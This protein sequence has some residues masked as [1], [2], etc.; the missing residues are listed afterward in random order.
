MTGVT[1]GNNDVTLVSVAGP[2]VFL[3][4]VNAGTGTVRF[5]SGGAVAQNSGGPITAR[6]LSVIAVNDIGLDGA[7]NNVNG[8]FAAGAKQRA[9]CPTARGTWQ[10]SKASSMLE[11]TCFEWSRGPAGRS[12]WS[13]L[14]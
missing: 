13:L 10:G 8:I 3:A 7:N 5:N 2:I 1:A 6:N 9:S 14:P 4:P 11:P 12:R